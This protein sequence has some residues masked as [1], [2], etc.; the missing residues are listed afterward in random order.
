MKTNTLP[1]DLR[2]RQGMI[3]VTALGVMLIV[4]GLLLVF[5]LNMRTEAQAAANRL[6]AVKADAIELGAEQWVLANVEGYPGDAVTI[7]TQTAQAMPVGDGYFWLIAPDDQNAQQ[8]D[9]GIVD[10]QGKINLNYATGTGLTT[11]APASTVLPQMQYLP[12]LTPDLA[13][14]IQDWASPAQY[15]TPDGAES[16]Y[17][18]SLKEPYDAK[19]APFETVEE[20]LLVRGIAAT[21]TT[22]DLLWNY[23]INHNG[24][25]DANELAAG[26]NTTMFNSGQDTS[27]GFFRDVTVWSTVTPAVPRSTTRPASPAQSK[28]NINTAGQDVLMCLGLSQADAQ[29]LIQARTGNS[30]TTSTSWVTST[31]GPAKAG[32]ITPFLTT[33]SYYYSADIVAVSGDGRA[34]KRV[35]IV[36]ANSAAT[37]VP[38][39]IVYRRDLTSLGW[40]LPT[41]IQTSLRAGKGLPPD[42]QVMTVGNTP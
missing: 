7:T 4:S 41:E 26:G 13:D 12:G 3:F 17:Y 1:I 30:N 10:E 23:D 38:A 35:R 24:V 34:F 31:L 40:P 36:V 33:S 20:L 25:L 9:Y 16:D 6:S 42:Q 22:P 8:Y 5:A 18:E 32:L 2:R 37:P 28:I 15:A 14:A 21:P 19:N 11:G 27:R 29:S 39:K